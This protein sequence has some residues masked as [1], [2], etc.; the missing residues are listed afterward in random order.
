MHNVDIW[1]ER[2]ALSQ[3]WES[4]AGVKKISFVLHVKVNDLSYMAPFF[5]KAKEKRKNFLVFF[6]FALFGPTPA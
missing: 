1:Q 2:H 6:V 3:Q 5:E 4:N